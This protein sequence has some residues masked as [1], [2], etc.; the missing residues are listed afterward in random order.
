[1][2]LSLKKPLLNRRRY[3]QHLGVG[4]GQAALLSLLG[5]DL[6]LIG[7]ESYS[8]TP[9][10]AFDLKPNQPHF[11]PMA[12]SVI[13]LFM[14]GGPS[15]MDLFDPK[16][17][18]VRNHGKSYFD[19]IAGEVE[20]PESAGA[21]LRSPFKFAQYGQSGMWVSDALPFF[22][23]CVDEVA[24]IRSMY[25]TSITHEP[26]LYKIHSGRLFPG[27]PSLGSWISYGLGSENQSLPAYVVLDDP[28]GPPIN[29]N[30]NWQSGYLP[31]VFQGTRFRSS[32]APVLDLNPG[33][34]VSEKI[35]G[36]ERDVIGSLDLLHKSQRHYQPRLGAR[37]ANYEL[38]AKMQ[39][40]ASDALDLSQ[41]SN[42]TKAMYGIGEK[43]TD[44]YGKRC[45]IA[46]RLVERG[47]RFVQL[48]IDGQIWDNHTG[49]KKG[50]LGACERTDKPVA[51]L[52]MDLRQR[53]LLDEIIVAWGG[54]MGRLPIAQL[55]G[56]KNEANSGRDHNKNAMVTWM[57][58]A[59]LKKGYVHGSTDEIGMK[60]VDNTVSVPDW[61][62]TLLHLLGL[63]YAKLFIHKN[64][65]EE[66]LVGVEEPEVIY[67]LLT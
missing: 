35:I 28:K 14:N 45:L 19:K 7:D 5:R 59:G 61:H 20:N 53:G 18:L 26:A 11:A 36:L 32:G 30:Q 37:I 67:G 44:S 47:V 34:E 50:L 52:L 3:F 51:G 27:H 38:A 13:H 4:L 15:Q 23:Q 25:T 1:M 54:E 2:K 49:L 56:K 42:A 39:L 8:S 33:K 9:D 60:A 62:A 64:G 24:M 40:E 22:S 66:R 6:S 55:D 12:K 48:F 10:A 63:D 16:P 58:G 31:P 57:A 21:L 17:E 43:K 41:E 46:R 29:R 65:L